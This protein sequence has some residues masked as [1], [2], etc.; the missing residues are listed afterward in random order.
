M[1]ALL[2]SLIVLLAAVAA[3]FVALNLGVLLDWVV[4]KA[5]GKLPAVTLSGF[6]TVAA[7]AAVAG[8]WLALQVWDWLAS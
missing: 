5:G 6:L 7:V 3:I 2:K 8:A 1:I 4:T